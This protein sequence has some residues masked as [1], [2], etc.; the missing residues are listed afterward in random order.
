MSAGVAP[1]Y[2][3]ARPA[4]GGG[5]V[6][7]WPPFASGAVGAVSASTAIIATWHVAPY[8]WWVWLPVQLAGFSFSLCGAVLWQRRSA[9][10]TGRLMAA[11][12]LTWY[13]GD[14]QLSHQPVL[15]AIGFCLFHMNSAVMGHLALALPTGRLHNGYERWVVALGYATL[16]VTQ[17]A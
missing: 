15:F 12:G 9:N 5:A 4:A 17:I 6:G 13:L 16:P 11:V 8:P 3:P 2:A 14:L 1:A 10:G 7:R